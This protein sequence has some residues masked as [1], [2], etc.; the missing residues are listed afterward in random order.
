MSVLYNESLEGRVTFWKFKVCQIR[1]QWYC[2]QNFG[3]PPFV[4]R[5]VETNLFMNF[6]NAIEWYV[7]ISS[8]RV[9]SGKNPRAQ[10]NEYINLATLTQVEFFCTIDSNRLAHHY[11]V[12]YVE[13]N[14]NCRL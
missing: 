4:W 13:K 7:I 5:R 6:R 12:S 3:T 8:T 1:L 2:R 9:I 14:P 11:L 10:S